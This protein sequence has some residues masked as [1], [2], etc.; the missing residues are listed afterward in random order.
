M[1]T[2]VT[3]CYK[4]VKKLKNSERTFCY[5]SMQAETET[6]SKYLGHKYE[7]KYPMPLQK[8]PRQERC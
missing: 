2:T 5:F 3:N 4:D 1:E 6:V 7:Q 8:A